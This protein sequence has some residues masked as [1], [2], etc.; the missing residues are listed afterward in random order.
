M[1]DFETISGTISIAKGIYQVLEFIRGV[2]G[3]A[4]IAAYFRYDGTK[5]EWSEKIEIQL[6]PDEKNRAI[7]WYS[8]KP[9]EEYVFVRVPVVESCAHELIGKIAGEALPDAKFWRWVAPILPGR[10][11]GGAEPEN[12]NVDFLVFGYKPKAL[13]KHFGPR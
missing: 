11:Y 5:V 1:I 10:V 12:L 3:S 8:V 9:V 6:H 4:V 2:T 13:I 7:W